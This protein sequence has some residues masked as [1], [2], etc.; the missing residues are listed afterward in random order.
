M[1][2]LEK[3]IAIIESFRRTQ[4]DECEDGFYS[5]PSH[6]DYFGNDDRSHCSCDLVRDNAK[7]D[8]ALQI[9]RGLTSRAGDTA[10]PSA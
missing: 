10:T 8:E 1:S 6:P 5:C 3:L 2:E 9:V 7:V 4:H